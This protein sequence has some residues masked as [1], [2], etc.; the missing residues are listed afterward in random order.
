MG[1]DD[2][3]VAIAEFAERAVAEA[4]WL[5][6]EDGGIPAALITEPGTFGMPVRH[7]VEVARRDVERA[8]EL[9][10]DR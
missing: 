10:S 5:R 9:L 3:L 1:R 8:H 7:R 4:V 6:V 2:Q